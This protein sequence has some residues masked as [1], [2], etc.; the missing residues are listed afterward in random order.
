MK[1]IASYHGYPTRLGNKNTGWVSCYQWK[2]F[3]LRWISG[4]L[5]CLIHNIQC[6]FHLRHL[7]NADE[8]ICN[9]EYTRNELLRNAKKFRWLGIKIKE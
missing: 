3:G 1:Y 4:A 2:P 8:I 6:Y 7:I 9:S 5:V